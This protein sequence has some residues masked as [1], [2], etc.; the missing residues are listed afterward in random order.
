M[1]LFPPLRRGARGDRLISP[2]TKGGEGGSSYFPPY[3]GGRGGIVIGQQRTKCDWQLITD[4]CYN[5]GS[6]DFE[7]S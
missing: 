2:L 6:V 7:A 1:V 4:N 5:K 3:K